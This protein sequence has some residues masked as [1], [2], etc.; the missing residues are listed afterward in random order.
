MIFTLHWIERSKEKHITLIVGLSISNEFCC[1]AA[2][3]IHVGF[4]VSRRILSPVTTL[5]TSP[6]TNSWSPWFHSRP[7]Y[8]VTLSTA[9]ALNGTVGW[10]KAS[11]CYSD[12]HS[13]DL[14]FTGSRIH[15]V[16]YIVY[17]CIRSCTRI[18]RL[19]LSD[20]NL[21][22]FIFVIPRKSRSVSNKSDCLVV[23]ELSRS[24][25]LTH[26]HSYQLRLWVM[27]V[28]VVSAWNAWA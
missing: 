13:H 17:A 16:R 26:Y 24:R 11:K 27:M 28:Y 22:L 23:I 18:D 4:V 6:L 15:Y 8:Q 14:I 10:R 12:T 3:E 9:M 21:R 7:G 19:R 2:D 1:T 20:S 5:R 25:D